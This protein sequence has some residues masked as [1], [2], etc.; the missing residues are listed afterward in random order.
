MFFRFLIAE[1]IHPDGE[2]GGPRTKPL[3][4][5]VCQMMRTKAHCHYGEHNVVSQL[6][7]AVSVHADRHHTVSIQV[8]HLDDFSPMQKFKYFKL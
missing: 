4:L 2:D 5:D 8:G 3:Y 6:G 1:D 7:A